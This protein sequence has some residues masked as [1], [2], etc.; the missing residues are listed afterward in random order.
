MNNPALT[1]FVPCSSIRDRKP[2]LLL[3]LT[4][5]NQADW[6]FYCTN[7]YDLDVPD[8][9]IWIGIREFAEALALYAQHPAV[10]KSV[11]IRIDI[12]SDGYEGKLRL[13]E[14][15]ISMIPFAPPH[16][17][18]FY[19]GIHF[20]NEWSDGAYWLDSDLYWPVAEEE[21]PAY[22]DTVLAAYG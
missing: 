3:S 6:T 18:P 2:Y 9:E 1:C 15:R 10:F 8:A 7:E 11:N 12:R 5:E 4:Q 17:R 21:L 22:L 19:T 14:L 16:C 13:D 20:I